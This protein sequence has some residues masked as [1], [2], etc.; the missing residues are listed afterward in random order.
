MSDNESEELIKNSL[1]DENNSLDDENNS[2]DN[3]N[4]S[5]DDENNSLDDENNI[6]LDNENNISLDNENNSLDNENNSLDNENNSLDN[7]IQRQHLII[8]EGLFIFLVF[9]QLSFGVFIFIKF[10]PIEFDNS[11]YLWVKFKNY[12]CQS[13]FN[14]TRCKINIYC[15]NSLYK[16]IEI[17]TSD[18]NFLEECCYWFGRYLEKPLLYCNPDCFL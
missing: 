16:W 8:K 5:L 11:S 15:N 4:N 17:Q 10:L 1:D 6:S 2:L 7:E 3:D 9:L 18:R 13:I 14:E 12:C